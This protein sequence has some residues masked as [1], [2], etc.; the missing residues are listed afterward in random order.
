VTAWSQARAGGFLAAALAR[1]EAWLLDPPSPRA[2]HPPAELP[3]RPVVVVR[4]LARGCGATTVAR[5]LAATLARGDPSGAAVIV[6]GPTGTGPRI[7]APAAVRLARA[8]SDAA[9]EGARASGRVCL[10]GDGEPLASIRAASACPVVVDVAHASPSAEG[11]GLADLTVLVASPTVEASL[12]AVVETS[13]AS[14]GHRVELVVNRVDS[15]SSFATAPFAAGSPEL[16]AGPACLLPRRGPVGGALEIGD[17]RLAA[18]LALAC[19]EAR[20]PF[21]KPIA[22]LA[23]R[24]RAAAR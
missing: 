23:E 2:P 12:V 18:Q 10:V 24:C 8:L 20:G 7:A 9:C 21:A 4:G 15:D 5:A 1:A 16:P 11:L 22:D 14:A 13:L 3:P 17:S 6:G 19:R